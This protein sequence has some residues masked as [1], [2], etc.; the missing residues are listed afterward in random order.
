MAMLRFGAALGLMETQLLLLVRR[1]TSFLLPLPAVFA[2]EINVSKNLLTGESSVLSTATVPTQELSRHA[3]LKVFDDG[4][5]SV[6]ALTPQQVLDL[7][8]PAS[9]DSLSHGGSDSDNNNI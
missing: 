2:V 9:M 3:G 5:K 6:Y 8:R 4:R 7:R 1:R